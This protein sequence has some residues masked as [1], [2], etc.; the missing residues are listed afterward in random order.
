MGALRTEWSA[1][2]DPRWPL[3]I[4]LY[5]VSSAAASVLT[6]VVWHRPLGYALGFLGAGVLGLVATARARLRLT[7]E[8]VEVR[9]LRTRLYRWSDIVSVQRAPEWEND[10]VI[11]LRQRGAVPSSA[12]DVLAP[13]GLRGRH[14]RDEAL[15]GLVVAIRQ[16]AGLDSN[17]AAMTP[18]EVS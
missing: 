17:G 8:G 6:V 18:L 13:P 9:G 14:A 12:P 10:S 5:V 7:D 2:D 3:T 11:W 16:R 1:T 15:E 4:L